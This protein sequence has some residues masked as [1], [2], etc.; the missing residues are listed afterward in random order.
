M[1]QVPLTLKCLFSSKLRVRILAHFFFRPGERFH[2]RRLASELDESVGSVGRELRNLAKAGVLSAQRVGNQKQYE[3]SADCPIVEDL[4]NLFLKTAGASVRL[5]NV[6]Q[7]MA[8][9]ELAFIFGSY[10]SGEANASSD[11]DL[12]VV[13]E[14][15]DRRLAPAVARVERDLGREINYTLYSR[16]DVQRRLGKIGDFIH[17]VFAGPRV[18]LI[19]SPDD[20]L[21]RTTE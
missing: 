16:G 21:L 2:V 17:E 9:V 14:L 8:G 15:S 1:E 6:L 10:A 3:V 11:I 19:G 13:G 4:R 5:R 7:H 12:M 18:L 20:R